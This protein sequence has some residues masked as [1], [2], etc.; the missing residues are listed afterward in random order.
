MFIIILSIS[1]LIA[2]I[3]QTNSFFK[4][5]IIIREDFLSIFE[6]TTDSSW[7]KSLIFILF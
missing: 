5:I 6:Q 4:A 3:F 7:I 1:I 2:V